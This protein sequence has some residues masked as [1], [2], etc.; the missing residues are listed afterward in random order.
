MIIS[1]EKLIKILR[2]IWEFPQHLLGHIL[3]NWYDVE[4]KE[5]YNGVDIYVGD[6]PGGISLGTYI[7][8][9]ETSYKDK[10]NRTKKH[11]YG[12]SKQSLYLGPLYLIVVGLPSLLWAGFIHNLVRKEIGYYDVYPENWADKLGEV[13]RNT[14]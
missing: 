12:H 10:R 11:E 2:W 4:Y 1:M 5:T 14:K 9:S 13:N 7:L 6:F 3:T 8:M